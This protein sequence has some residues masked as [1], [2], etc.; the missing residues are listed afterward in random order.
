MADVSAEILRKIARVSRG[1]LDPTALLRSV[2][3]EEGEGSARR[4]LAPAAIYYDL[5]ER[6]H[7]G[8]D[9]ELPFRYGASITPEDFGAFG[10][11]LK[12]APSV[13]E[14]LERLARY[15]LVISDTM[16]YGLLDEPGGRAFF[17]GGRPYEERFGVRLANECAL[18]AVIAIL[19]TTATGPIVPLSVAFRHPPPDERTYH[20]RFFGCTVRFSA[21]LDALHFTHE[22]L[23]IPLRLRDEG[24]SS[25]L[26]AQLEHEH[27][28]RVEPSLVLRVRS[29]ITDLLC[30]GAPRKSSVARQ[31]GMS[32]RT[33]Q[34]RLSEE[35]QSFQGLVSQVRREVA[36]S[37]LS[38]T[39]QS[40]GEVAFLTGF[41]DQSAFQRAFKVWTGKTPLG[42]R[43]ASPST[44]AFPQRHEATAISAMWLK[45][46]AL[47]RSGRV[48]LE[49]PLRRLWLDAS[50][51]WLVRPRGK[52]ERRIS[53]W[54]QPQPRENDHDCCKRRTNTNAHCCPPHRACLPRYHRFRDFR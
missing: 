47:E 19:R 10:L 35:G 14:A 43:Q 28:Q 38:R 48:G 45:A 33:L 17:L 50:V 25:F 54:H 1:S 15:V 22:S 31:L 32:E 39:G 5:L 34:R 51:V 2:G 21:G 27:E 13:G 3:F 40:L 23:A 9:H 46:H 41:S 30:E 42:Y 12:T 18:A 16:T 52:C 29:A 8:T 20:E 4:A 37:L 26:L 11:A 24:L 49:P 53:S 36:E 7:D 6:C 44:F